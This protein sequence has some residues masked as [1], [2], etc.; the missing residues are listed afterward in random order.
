MN[1]MIGYQPDPEEHE[2]SIHPGPGTC[3]PKML[4]RDGICQGCGHLLFR[5]GKD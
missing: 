3:C 5:S 2:I 1:E 4:V